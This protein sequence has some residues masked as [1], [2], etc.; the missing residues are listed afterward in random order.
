MNLYKT[1][2]NRFLEEEEPEKE[3]PESPVEKMMMGAMMFDKKFIEQRKLFLWGVVDDKSAKDIT[4]RLLYLDAM[5][6]GK[7]ITF[8]INSP[9]G[10]IT[11]GMVI[12]DTMKMISSPVSTVCMGMA[13]SMGSIL[14]SG[15]DKGKRF[16]F[17]HGEVMIHQPSG[18]GQGTS[19]DLEIM[20]VQIL[21]AKQLGAQILADNCGQTY[22]KVME[23]F[24][25]DYWMDS[26]E[27]KKYGI[28]DDILN[29]L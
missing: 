21:K 27:S 19:A 9:G 7:E 17:P 25:R 26:K 24:D 14:L 13:A 1:Y 10:A 16:I 22:D 20:A 15:G 11:S 3:L 4:N 8:Y 29:K 2:F 23:D 6:P 28:V 5:E 12:Y 18:G